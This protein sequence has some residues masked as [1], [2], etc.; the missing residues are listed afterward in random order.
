MAESKPEQKPHELVEEVTGVLFSAVKKHKDA[1]DRAVYNKKIEEILDP[2]VD[3]PFIARVVMGNHGKEASGEQVQR[4]AKVFKEGLVSTY[5]RGI[6]GYVDSEVRLMPPKGDL[7]GQ[8][9][10]SVDQEVHNG[11]EIHHLSYTMALNNAGEWKV[12]NVV[13]NGV[14]LGQSFRSQFTQAMRK[15]GNDIDKVIDNW[16]ADA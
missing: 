6:A 2:V 7:A 3:F 8:R 14:N 9:R 10:V 12:I 13:L 15:H 16:L 11:N 5:A 4:F 1:S